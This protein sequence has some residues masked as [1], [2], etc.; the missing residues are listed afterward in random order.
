ME[1]NLDKFTELFK[2]EFNQ[3]Y[4]E[5]ERKIHVAPAQLYRIMNKKGKAGALFLGK[6]YTY[7]KKNR[8]KFEDYIIILDSKKYRKE[9]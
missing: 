5:A 9:T 3:S 2:S 7:C 8:L 6:L 1:L 4:A